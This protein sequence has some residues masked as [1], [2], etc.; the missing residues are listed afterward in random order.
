MPPGISNGTHSHIYIYAPGVLRVTLSYIYA[1]GV[2]RDTLSYIYAPGVSRVTFS[3][4][5]APGVS[6]VTLSHIYT[7][8]YFSFIYNVPS[9]M[10]NHLNVGE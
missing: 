2:S 9:L 8:S 1:P 4:I 6:R 10:K 5:Y 7:F 3:H